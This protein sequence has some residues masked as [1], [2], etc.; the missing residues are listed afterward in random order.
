L[1]VGTKVG[2]YLG[3]IQVKDVRIQEFG[4]HIQEFRVLLLT[5]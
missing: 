3:W 2:L 1:F 4:V 5:A